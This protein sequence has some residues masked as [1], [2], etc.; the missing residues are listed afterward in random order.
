MK[1]EGR[2]RGCCQRAHFQAAHGDRPGSV[3]PGRACWPPLS[4]ALR[5]DLSVSQATAGVPG[6]GSKVS[7]RPGCQV[8]GGG[9]HSFPLETLSEQCIVNRFP[10]QHLS[11]CRPGVSGRLPAKESSAGSGIQGPLHPAAPLLARLPLLGSQVRSGCRCD[12]GGSSTV[13]PTSPSLPT[14]A[15]LSPQ[16][17]HIRAPH[18]CPVRPP[19]AVTEQNFGASS[20][21]FQHLQPPAPGRSRSSPTSQRP[22]SPSFLVLPSDRIPL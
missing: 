12:S 3:P 5:L 7:R 11:H 13:P 4:P 8:Q 6:V 21:S 14:V 18:P 15:G 17:P 22:G 9:H 16:P 1:S 2:G 10:G 20:L 19:S